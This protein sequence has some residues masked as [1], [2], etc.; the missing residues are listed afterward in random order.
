MKV[1]RIRRLVEAKRLE[2][3]QWFVVEDGKPEVMNSVDF[4]RTYERAP[5]SFLT[6]SIA[7]TVGIFLLWTATYAMLYLA[8]QILRSLH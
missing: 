8:S 6:V 2:D 4:L 7:I 1:V 5:P 3:G